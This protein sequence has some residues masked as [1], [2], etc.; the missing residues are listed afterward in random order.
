MLCTLCD[1][2]CLW[3]ACLPP[4]HRA[5]HALQAEDTG[6]EGHSSAAAMDGPA[7]EGDHFDVAVEIVHMK[8]KPLRGESHASWDTI[9]HRA[10]DNS[11]K[12][13]SLQI[14]LREPSCAIFCRVRTDPALWSYQVM[15]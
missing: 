6:S 8:P 9:W 14:T 11:G 7:E 2:I 1:S 4:Q 13:H 3:H 10:V 5:F 12:L 15:M